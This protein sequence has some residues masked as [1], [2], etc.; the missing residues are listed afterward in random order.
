MI[1]IRKKIFNT[2]AAFIVLSSFWGCGG[3]KTPYD[4]QKD[5]NRE[6]INRR[7]AEIKGLVG[8]YDGTLLEKRSARSQFI[9]LY[10][11]LSGEP[12][13]KDGVPDETTAPT[14]SA[15]IDYY[16]SGS[17]SGIYDHFEFE[18]SDYDASQRQITFYSVKPEGSLEIEIKEQ[19]RVL[20]GIWSI[21]TRGQM[22]TFHVERRD[23]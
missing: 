18:H 1:L 3:G 13:P 22:G 2:F 7:K 20:E 14:L 8:E 9:R 15:N 10:I 21:V 23:H 19:G 6:E 17:S 12:F 11:V 16:G 5:R 4:L